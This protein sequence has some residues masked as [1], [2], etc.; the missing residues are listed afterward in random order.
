MEGLSPL[1]LL[2]RTVVWRQS[3]MPRKNSGEQRLTG[4]SSRLM[5][6]AEESANVG[7]DALLRLEALNPDI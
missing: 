2:G 1:F 7:A 3:S 5:R 6:V 4:L